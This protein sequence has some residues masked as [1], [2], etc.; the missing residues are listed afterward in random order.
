[1]KPE[2]AKYPIVE[3]IGLDEAHELALD[4]TRQ[5]V[6]QQHSIEKLQVKVAF[7]RQL[8]ETQ[9]KHW[10]DIMVKCRRV[11][12]NLERHLKHEEEENEDDERTTD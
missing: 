7:I 6:A 2:T 11:M 1:M 8:L 12:I 9:H 5:L 3:N 10:A 4:L